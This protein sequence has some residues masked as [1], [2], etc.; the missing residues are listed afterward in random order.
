MIITA[1]QASAL[2][3]MN[4]NC[5]VKQELETLD[6][7]IRTTAKQGLSY[8]TIYNSLSQD[9][10]KELKRK[11]YDIIENNLTEVFYT[12]K[13][14]RDIKNIIMNKGDICYEI[15]RY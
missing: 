1:N 7:I 9:T 4:L 14:Q 11:G 12:I 2:T 3:S 5:A 10:I 15:R 13:W 6:K 8:C